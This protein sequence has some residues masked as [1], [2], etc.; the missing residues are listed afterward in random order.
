MKEPLISIIIP[1][2]NVGDLLDKCFKS[3]DAQNYKNLEIIIV[4]DGSTDN[5]G[6][7]CD[8][9]AGQK[10]NVKV[11]HKE[12]G[13]VSAA[14][15]Y[16]IKRASGEFVAFID[17]DD[18]VEKDYIQYL[19]SLIAKYNTDISVCQ[20][21]VIYQNGRELNYGKNGDVL[22]SQQSCYEK[23]LYNKEID[24]TPWAKLYRLKLF[25]GIYYP[26]GVLFDD[27]A[28]TYKLLMKCENIACGYETK[29]NYYLR[30]G[31]I[32]NGKFSQ[33]K[34]DYVRLTDQMADCIVEKYFALQQAALARKVRA[35]FSIIDLIINSN[36][37][38]YQKYI[39]E[40]R[41]YIIQNRK[42]IIHDKNVSKGMKCAVLIISC[43]KFI[44]KIMWK[45]YRRGAI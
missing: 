2:Y 3:I 34:F 31:S 38:G 12:N 37:K 4:D 35:R 16:A 32:S 11:F 17:A 8:I 19:Y 15:N 7:I 23:M 24:V 44:Y 36:L 9:Y 13:G 40:Y 33:K 43:S 20:H 41:E 25:N 6:K 26:D 21:K 27:L 30:E 42:A 45:I 28:T 14:R 10:E 18:T 5:S 39:D 22:L 1:V 29:Y